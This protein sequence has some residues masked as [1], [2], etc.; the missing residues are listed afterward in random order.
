MGIPAP[1]PIRAPPTKAIAIPCCQKSTSTLEVDKYS[2]T[3]NNFDP[4]K[5]SPPSSWDNRL[6]ARL[7]D[8]CHLGAPLSGTPLPNSS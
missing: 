3:L 4:N 7:G 2:L 6:R 5:F 8:D 1:L